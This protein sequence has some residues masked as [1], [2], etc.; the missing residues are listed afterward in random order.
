[1]K[2][3]R[4]A[5]M[6]ASCIAPIACG[7]SSAT[8]QVSP[9]TGPALAAEVSADPSLAFSPNTVTILR[10]GSVTIDFGRVPHNVYFDNQP[11]GAPANITGNN[12]DVTKS[13]TFTTAGT[14]VYNC[15]IH[16]GMQGTVVVVDPQS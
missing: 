8:Q 5:V 3:S 13:L 12:S 6:L 14:F 7:G 15:H 16:P 10:G 4:L 11:A 2:I 1:M 9:P